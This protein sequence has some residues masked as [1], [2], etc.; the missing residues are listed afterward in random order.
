[1]MWE[2][3]QVNSVDDLLR[4]H[5][6]VDDAEIIFQSVTD[7]CDAAKIKFSNELVTQANEVNLPINQ[8]SELLI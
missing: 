3:K 8:I 7:K 5:M 2:V 6:Q 4:W 1:M